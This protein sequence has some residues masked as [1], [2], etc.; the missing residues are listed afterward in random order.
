M[1]DQVTSIPSAG[2]ARSP[3]TSAERRR[4]MA[5][6]LAVIA[7]V[8][9][10]GLALAALLIPAYNGETVSALNGVTLTRLTLVQSHSPWI[11][12]LVMFPLPAALVTLASLLVPTERSVAV[13]VGGS[14]FDVREARRE[15]V[16]LRRVA[17]GATILVALEG[18]VA[19][20]SVGAFLLPVAILSGLALGLSAR[21]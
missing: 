21:R 4:Y 17:T 9:A 11:V 6:R 18:V 16:V 19:I 13:E 12:T 15:V 10:A 2:I 7:A 1:T 5:R 8:W 3:S 14:R 20:A